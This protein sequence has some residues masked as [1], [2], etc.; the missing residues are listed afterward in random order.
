MELKS[1]KYEIDDT[2]DTGIIT[3]IKGINLDSEGGGEL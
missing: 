3:D 1:N 2:K